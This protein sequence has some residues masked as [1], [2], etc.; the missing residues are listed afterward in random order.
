M[1]QIE[2]T[3]NLK[4]MFKQKAIEDIYKIFYEKKENK[5]FINMQELFDAEKIIVDSG[6]TRIMTLWAINIGNGKSEIMEDGIIKTGDAE[7]MFKFALNVNRSNKHK[8]RRAI[9]ETKDKYWIKEWKACF[10][11][12]GL[13]F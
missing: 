8:L 9:M 10:G 3:N 6:D 2:K 13:F 12:E 7:A 11:L 4:E 5:E 1:G